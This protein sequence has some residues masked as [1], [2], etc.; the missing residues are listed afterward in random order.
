MKS[1]KMLHKQLIKLGLDSLN[2]PSDSESWL[3][4]LHM[5]Q[6]SY[7][8][9]NKQR[10][11]NENMIDTAM[12]EM[13]RLNLLIQKQAQIEVQHTEEKFKNIVEAVPSVVCWVDKE[14]YILGCN[15]KLSE[16]LD[17]EIEDLTGVRFS[18]LGYEQIH[19]ALQNLIQAS[20]QETSLDHVFNDDLDKKYYKFLFKKFSNDQMIVVVG[21][22][23][24]IDMKKS[25][26]LEAAQSA[27]L[28]A[29][30]MATLGE[31]ASGIA[32]EVNNPLAV[33]NSIIH[34]IKKRLDKNEFDKIPERLDKIHAIVLR[35][36]KIISGLRTFARDGE[37]DPFLPSSIKKIVDET[38]E[39]AA[40]RLKSLNI[41]LRIDPMSDELSIDCRATQISQVLL[42]LINNAR[43]AIQRLPTK[44]IQIK[45][46]DCGDKIRISVIDSG[47]GIPL[48][49]QEKM[50]RPFYTTKEVGVGTGL[51]LS[52]SIGII[53]TH[54]GRLYIEQASQ[55]THFVIELPKIQPE[56]V[57]L[58][59]S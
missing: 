43:D 26:E 22:D 34:Q 14:G 46:E 17:F 8:Q 41:D 49:V 40:E 55:N 18:D 31:M 28:A 45:F 7:E 13:D 16:L 52:I 25:N 20:F 35:V 39:L 57:Q 47:S 38:L 27:T 9:N 58:K 30:R 4:F 11:L 29:S 36:S 21:I 19:R 32:H 15:D 1:G 33:I 42:N 23:L 3:Q 24:T 53:Q 44:W 50:F 51:G 12:F 37:K 54:H 10:T 6:E 48:D 56:D 5:V 59:A 2:P